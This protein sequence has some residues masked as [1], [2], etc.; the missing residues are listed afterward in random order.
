LG[1]S[2]I[3][4][5]PFENRLLVRMRVDGILRQIR[6]REIEQAIDRIRLIYN[7]ES[8]SVYLLTCIPIEAEITATAVW[9]RFLPRPHS[10]IGR[11]ILRSVEKIGRITAGTE[12]FEAVVLPF[13]REL[14]RCFPEIFPSPNAA[15]DDWRD[16]G[17]S[18]GGQL[19]INILFANAP[20]LICAYRRPGARGKPSHALVAVRPMRGIHTPQNGTNG[21][22]PTGPD[23]HAPTAPKSPKSATSTTAQYGISVGGTVLPAIVPSAIPDD[24]LQGVAAI[25]LQRITGP[26]RLLSIEPTAGLGRKTTRRS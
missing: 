5:E 4:I 10:R 21:P 9:A 25:A 20:H 3:H 2:D 15:R 26:V 23:E 13:G 8:K 18:N 19:Q 14:G 6:E 1:A 24:G 16:G 11:A 17:E 7:L 12:I 22:D